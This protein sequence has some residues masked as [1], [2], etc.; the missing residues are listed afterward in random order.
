MCVEI[1]SS[2]VTKL[3][4]AEATSCSIDIPITDANADANRSVKQ[5]S[6]TMISVPDANTHV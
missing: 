3:F 5:R 2:E 4:L 1:I 6:R